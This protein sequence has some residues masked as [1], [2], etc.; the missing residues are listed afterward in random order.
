MDELG[1]RFIFDSQDCKSANRQNLWNIQVSSAEIWALKSMWIWNLPVSSVFNSIVSQWMLSVSCTNLKI[2]RVY[3]FYQHLLVQQTSTNTFSMFLIVKKTYFIHLC[4]ILY[5]N[6]LLS[7]KDPTVGI[8]SNSRAQKKSLP[9][10]SCKETC[11]TNGVWP[12]GVKI[13]NPSSCS[14]TCQGKI[15][16]LFR[17]IHWSCHKGRG[18]IWKVWLNMVKQNVN[19][20]TCSMILVILASR[21]CMSLAIE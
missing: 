15:A 19:T 17:K 12:F 4:T 5:Y 10:F 6:M 18:L 9:D 13:V 8:T 14:N 20:L 3:K 1:F 2:K 7:S 11:S 21:D 16:K